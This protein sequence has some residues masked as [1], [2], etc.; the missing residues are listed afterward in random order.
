MESSSQASPLRAGKE[1]EVTGLYAEA[2]RVR[3]EPKTPAFEF[4]ALLRAL[5]LTV[6]VHEPSH[7][8]LE[9]RLCDRIIE[10]REAEGRLR[11]LPPGNER[12]AAELCRLIARKTAAEESKLARGDPDSRKAGGQRIGELLVG[13]SPRSGMPPL[14]RV[15]VCVDLFL[16]ILESKD[17]SGYS[18]GRY[19]TRELW[20]EMWGDAHQGRQPSLNGQAPA[21]EGYVDLAIRQLLSKGEDQHLPEIPSVSGK[22]PDVDARPGIRPPDEG[23]QAPPH[24]PAGPPPGGRE[25]TRHIERVQ[26]D[27]SAARFRA[28]A[29]TAVVI[30]V[31]LAVVLAAVLWTRW[32]APSVRDTVLQVPVPYS[33]SSVS[34]Q[35]SEGALSLDGIVG[36]GLGRTAVLTLHLK[37]ASAAP[38]DACVHDSQLSYTL[39][40][41]GTVVSSGHVQGQLGVMTIGPLRI[42]DVGRGHH[43]RLAASVAVPSI[44]SGCQFSLDPSG[45]FM[46]SAG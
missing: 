5:S 9:Q 30:A 41:D 3:R 18:E 13:K 39:S 28:I 31:G 12:E 32:P 17:H 25:G 46:S 10:G 20:E 27:R 43:L 38:A 6:T 36:P 34:P 35:V 44:E 23:L 45:T 8:K 2:S 14:P 22:L 19:G 1:R 24:G 40:D 15:A 29:A 26:R 16:E 11:E 4:I 42:G 37:L 33:L 21:V 7:A